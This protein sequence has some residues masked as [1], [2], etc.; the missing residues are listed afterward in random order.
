VPDG[1]RDPCPR[2]QRATADDRE[3]YADSPHTHS[4][5]PTLTC[6]EGVFPHPATAASLTPVR[7]AA[8]YRADIGRPS[9][10]DQIDT[11]GGKASKDMTEN[12]IIVGQA[13][14]T[15]GSALRRGAAAG[16]R[17]LLLLF[18]VAG[19]V[20]IFLAGLGVFHL[21]S[22]GLDDPAGDSALDPHRTLGF[23]MGGIAVLI[24]VLALFARP[25]A[26]Q[27][28]L[29]AVLVLQTVLLQSLLAGL[30]DDSAVWGGLHALDGLLALGVAGYLYGVALV[31]RRA[32]ARDLR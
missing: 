25:G 19:V 32:T 26:R 8:G 7:P 17:W 13:A 20:Q 11:F 30:G 6:W 9:V 21:H 18:L 16:Y 12:Q 15:S 3:E 31:R 10:S 2:H 28:V 14:S 5:T 22:Y 24:L 23:A 29:A 27:V 1:Q 4:V